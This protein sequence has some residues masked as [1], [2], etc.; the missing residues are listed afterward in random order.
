MNHGP[1]HKSWNLN[2][3][4]SMSYISW[5]PQFINKNE[6]QRSLNLPRF[7]F[8]KFQVFLNATINNL[9]WNFF[10]SALNLTFAQCAKWIW[11]RELWNGYLMIC[12]LN[13]WIEIGIIEPICYYNHQPHL[14]LL[15]PLKKSC[16]SKL[17]KFPTWKISLRNLAKFWKT[18]KSEFFQESREKLIG[19]NGLL[20]GHFRGQ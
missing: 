17:K 8:L 16:S 4:F 14:I 12:K 3:L 9:H 13:G 6:F 5:P 1:L 18:E 10:F 20:F 11:M 19:H 2:D 15:Q 7:N